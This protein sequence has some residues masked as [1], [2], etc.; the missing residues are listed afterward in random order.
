MPINLAKAKSAIEDY[1]TAHTLLHQQ[2]PPDGDVPSWQVSDMHNVLTNAMR[3]ETN[4]WGF[5]HEDDVFEASDNEVLGALGYSSRLDFFNAVYD[6]D[7]DVISGKES[8]HATWEA[9]WR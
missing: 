8:D 1:R 4:K 2:N 9:R 5:A 6:V 7:G 3:K